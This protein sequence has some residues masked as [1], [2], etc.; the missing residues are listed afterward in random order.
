[1]AVYE[2]VLQSKEPIRHFG[3][4]TFANKNFAAYESTHLPL[5]LDGSSVDIILVGLEF[6]SQ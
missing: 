1:M 3:R 2:R 6:F 4:P 5:S